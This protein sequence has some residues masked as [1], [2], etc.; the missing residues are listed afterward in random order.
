MGRPDTAI[1]AKHVW[2]ALNFTYIWLPPPQVQ[3]CHTRTV[4]I[5]SCTG[6]VCFCCI[7][8]IGANYGYDRSWPELL[9]Y[10]NSVVQLRPICERQV[11]GG[12][13]KL[14]V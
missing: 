6:N 1:G 3:R 13:R 2:H 12:H 10:K 11:C 5:A 9:L 8:V 14:K 7:P 4:G